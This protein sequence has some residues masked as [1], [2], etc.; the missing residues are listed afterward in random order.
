MTIKCYGI[1]SENC[2][3]MRDGKCTLE[4]EKAECEESFEVADDEDLH[5]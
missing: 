4:A 3:A 5:R 2:S 1:C